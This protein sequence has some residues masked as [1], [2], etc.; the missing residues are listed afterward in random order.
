MPFLLHMGGA[1]II[2]SLCHVVFISF[3]L[4]LKNKVN[5][6]VITFVSNE[7]FEKHIFMKLRAQFNS[8]SILK[9]GQSQL[10]GRYR[11]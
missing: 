6:Y 1:V 11:K 9:A 4:I 2:E 10:F 7:L 5:K 3:I 8:L